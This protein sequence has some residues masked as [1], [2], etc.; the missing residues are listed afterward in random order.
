MGYLDGWTVPLAV[1]LQG[2]DG[3]PVQA[4]IPWDMKRYGLIL[5]RHAAEG[6]INRTRWPDLHGFQAALATSQPPTVFVDM[7]DIAEPRFQNP[8]EAQQL[9]HVAATG[10]A[11]P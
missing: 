8:L 3:V 11:R 6:R 2:P 9:A 7:G 1:W 10:P 5:D 4:R